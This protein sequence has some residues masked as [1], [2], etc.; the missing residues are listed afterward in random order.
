[1]TGLAH[2]RG[3]LVFLIDSDLEEDPG[4]AAARSARC[5][6]DRRRRRL[7]RA[8][9]RGAAGSRTLSGWAVLQ[10]VQRAVATADP[11]QS[12]H[13]APD[14]AALRRR[15]RRAP[16]ARDHPRRAVDDHRLPS[17]QPCRSPS[18]ARLDVD[19]RLP[20]KIAMLVNAVTSFS[21]RPLVL[22]FYLGAA[23][24]CL[25]SVAAAY[26]SS[27]AVLRRLLPA[28]RRSSSRSGCS[29]A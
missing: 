12:R 28:G 23:I 14:D 16:R 22:I 27:P 3:D 13:R 15:A 4:A 10:A 5:C 17:G 8:G 25:A 11:D 1:M 6:S 29:A 21:D 9:P 7:R 20:H 19:L 24:V 2:A 18:D 26:L